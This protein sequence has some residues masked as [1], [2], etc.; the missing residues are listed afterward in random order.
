MRTYVNLRTGERLPAAHCKVREGRLEHRVYRKGIVCEPL[1][2]FVGEE[3]PAPPNDYTYDQLKAYVDQYGYVC[4]RVVA[5]LQEL[6]IALDDGRPDDRFFTWFA[7]TFHASLHDFMDKSS[8]R[9]VFEL[10]RFIRFLERERGY[11]PDAECL[12]QFVYRVYGDRAC[13]FIE[14]KICKPKK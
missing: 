9:F 3:I 10:S 14:R 12:N 1:E 8:S 2:D 4:A 5:P 11:D 6:S 13:E 7:L